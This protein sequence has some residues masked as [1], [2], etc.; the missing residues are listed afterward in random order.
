M[1]ELL[2]TPKSLCVLWRVSDSL[3]VC[4]GSRDVLFGRWNRFEWPA[5]LFEILMSLGRVWARAPSS[6]SAGRDELDEFGFRGA[7]GERWGMEG[8]L[9]PSRSAFDLASKELASSCAALSSQCRI[10]RHRSLA[11]MIQA[12]RY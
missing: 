8:I 4:S 11:S 9:S 10:R 5:L 2:G 6:S 3:P 1:K 7:R 12:Q